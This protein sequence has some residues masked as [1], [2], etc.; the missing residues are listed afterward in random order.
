MSSLHELLANEGFNGQKFHKDQKKKVKFREKP[1]QDESIALPIYI[2]H[3]RKG[4]NFTRPKSDKASSK[5]GSSVY[6]SKRGGSDSGKSNKTQ[7]M[8]MIK[9]N[10]NEAAI[11]EAAIKAVISILSG[12]AGQYLRD[13]NFRKSVREKCYSCFKRRRTESESNDGVFVN[14]EL[15]IESIE[16]LVESEGTKKEMKMKSLRNSIGFLSI[17]ASLNSKSTKNGSTCGT[18]N[19][20]LSACAQL[21]LSIVYKLEKNDRISSRHL[22]QVFCDSPFLARTHLLPELWEHFF[23][24]HLLHI[25]IWY[26]KE[27]DFILNSKYMEKEKKMKALSEVY[28]EQMDK[29]TIQF[30]LYYKE[31]LKTGVEAPPPLPSL[32]LPSRPNY[33]NSRRRSSESFTSHSS[34]NKSL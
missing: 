1:P 23:L 26:G 16:K 27:V 33:G 20:H 12:Y 29:G 8:M 28:N 13:E 10:S 4:F 25:K 22:L 30:A 14:M 24:P 11:D 15:G 6:S 2:C 32:P 31:W 17:V 34:I 7:V 3:D 21:Y 18:P 5:N 9:N 19:S